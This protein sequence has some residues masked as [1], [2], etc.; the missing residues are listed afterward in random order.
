MSFTL[1]VQLFW[2]CV[3]EIV[4]VCMKDR[5]E[6]IKHSA[7]RQERNA[8]G[9]IVFN[10]VRTKTMCNFL[11]RA[12]TTLAPERE[13]P[14]FS[15]YHYKVVLLFII[16]KFSPSLDNI[17]VVVFFVHLFFLLGQFLVF[18]KPKL[19]N[20]HKDSRKN[21]PAVGHLLLQWQITGS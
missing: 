19:S 3:C 1:T 21:I 11:L 8:A 20:T 12:E 9:R 18:F 10:Q 5:V 6:V 2:Q 4:N 15:K 17:L 16:E 14:P 7:K 13:Y